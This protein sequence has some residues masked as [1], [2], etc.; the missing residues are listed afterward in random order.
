MPKLIHASE[1]R[2]EEQALTQA[3]QDE[4]HETLLPLL[5]EQLEQQATQLKAFE[6]ARGL[7]GA[8]DLLRASGS[9]HAAGGGAA[10]HLRL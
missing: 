2:S 3:L 4:W 9:D 5:P 1:T 7:R 8:G 6:R 10:H